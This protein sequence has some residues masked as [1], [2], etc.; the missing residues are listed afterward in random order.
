[1]SKVDVSHPQNS[2]RGAGVLRHVERTLSRI[3]SQFE[4][5]A[6]SPRLSKL[7]QVKH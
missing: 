3:S 1:M 2:D 7:E 5:S 6:V 4:Y